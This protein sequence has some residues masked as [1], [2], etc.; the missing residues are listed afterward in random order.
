MICPKCGFN[1]PEDIYCARCGVN[2]KK[3]HQKQK[4]KTLIILASVLIITGGAALFAG[5]VYQEKGTR[6]T[7]VQ[8]PSPLVAR[9]EKPSQMTKPKPTPSLPIR[10]SP[11]RS[12]GQKEK[13]P[14]A[15]TESRAPADPQS[16]VVDTPS[17]KEEKGRTAKEKEDVLSA[18]Q[19][20]E[21]GTALNDDS[22]VEI[23]CY[24]KAIELD[25]AFAPAYYR[26]GA[27]Y[28]RNAEYELADQAF[29]RFLKFATDEQKGSYDI[30]VFYSPTEVE[31]LGGEE[32]QP[33]STIAS[34]KQPSGQN[35]SA[36]PGQG[37]NSESKKEGTF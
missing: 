4:K 14:V 19:W 29:A 16:P 13:P 8:S 35:K 27:I 12:N 18:L 5:R 2:V 10:S 23:A 32:S 6:F 1:Q 7:V 15:T 28:F 22:T 34:K 33:G 3:Y 31:S 20:F 11:A 26:L 36:S 17:N 9:L 24:Q 21:R 30:Y 37:E 25:P